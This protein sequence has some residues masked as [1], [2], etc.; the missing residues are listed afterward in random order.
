[1]KADEMEV[2][3]RLTNQKVQFTGG[4][5]SNPDIV[6]DY[7]PPLGDGQG[8]TGLELLLMSLAACS[9]TSVVYLLR[10]MGK[11]VQGLNIHAKGI[12]RDAHPTSFRQIYL[13][14]T[15]TSGDVKDQDIQKAIKLSEESLCP[16]WAMLKNSVE[17]IPG[18]KIIDGR[19]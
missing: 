8:Y 7:F 16:V 14:F 11:N 1:M 18:H 6:M 2:A 15:I 10:K 12:R 5:R 13:E 9:G 19:A 17:V 3:V 4:A